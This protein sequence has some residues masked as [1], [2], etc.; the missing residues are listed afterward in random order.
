MKMRKT[1]LI[2]LLVM[3]I[4]LA[5]SVV[6]F[7]EDINLRF[8]W[9]GNQVRNERTFQVIKLFEEKYPNVKIQAEFLSW[10]DYWS[11]MSVQA[12]GKNLPD[13]FTQSYAYIFEYVEKDM[14][15]NLTPYVEDNRLDFTTTAE[16][17]INSCT[18]NGNIYAAVLGINSNLACAYDPELF[19]KAG[20]EEP[21][22]D[23]TW[24]DYIE[25]VRKIHTALGIYGDDIN[26]A[27]LS[28]TGP[29]QYYLAQHGKL[30]YNKSLTKLGYEDDS[31]FVDY[32]TM[33]TNL[34]K[35]GVNVPLDMSLNVSHQLENQLIV[36]K[37]AAMCS[38]ISTNQFYALSKATGR[39]LKLA[40]WPNAKDQV[41]YGTFMTPSMYL[42]VAKNCKYPEWAVKFI[43][44]FYNDIEAN[45]ILLVERGVP[46]SSKVREGIMP[47][48]GDIN[49]EL[50]AFTDVLSKHSSKNLIIYPKVHS[51]I[52][53]IYN[54]I[55][56][57]VCY[58]EL[59]PEEA[60]KEFREKANKLLAEN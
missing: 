34:T 48:L 4:F 33:V 47:Y 53:E 30:L 56:Q 17:E 45:K 50:L 40:I 39:P 57:K 20:V 23:W 51:Q 41:Q 11:K 14:L 22:L 12:A 25:T 19:K 7:T 9:W 10:V 60:A 32:I 37:K 24:E 1:F 55:Y 52:V 31:L 5:I 42:V 46:A 43:D 8:A 6:S 27:N 54:L 59:T 21:T 26:G 3:M 49:K 38:S 28:I 15:L 35:E 29:L 2:V 16:T 18:F 13:I 58:G 44:F 36:R